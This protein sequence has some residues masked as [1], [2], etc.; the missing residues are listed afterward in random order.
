MGKTWLLS[1]NPQN[2]HWE[3]Y[4]SWAAGTK[5][6]SR[7][8]EPWTCQSKQPALGEE[9]FLMKTGKAPRGIIGHGHIVR[10]PYAAPHYDPVRA[11]KGDTTNHIDAEF[12]Y[13]LD[14]NREKILM[15]S[16]LKECY[17]EQQWSPQGSGISIKPEIVPELKKMWN[18]MIVKA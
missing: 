2:W 13:L 12:D 7:Y 9:F 14:Y 15:Q 10:E 17:P 1:W 5:K 18:S 4:S 3:D 6:G 11:S 8:I 16:S